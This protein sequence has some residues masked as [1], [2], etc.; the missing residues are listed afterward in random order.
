ML[1]RS[2][3]TDPGREVRADDG[4]PGVTNLLTILSV[5]TGTP[6]P[7]LETT[8]EGKGYGDFKADVAAAVVELFA[9]VRERYTALI[10]DPG[11]LDEVLADGAQRAAAVARAKLDA[12]RAAVGLLPA[13]GR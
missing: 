10:A 9:P 8:Y 6:V 1:F 5:A 3:V 2:A 7:A 12:V 4:K 11:H 13:L